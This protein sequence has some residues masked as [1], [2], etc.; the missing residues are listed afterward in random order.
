MVAGGRS[1]DITHGYVGD[2]R[3]PV[4]L[5][6]SETAHRVRRQQPGEVLDGVHF[7]NRTRRGCRSR[8]HVLRASVDLVRIA[9]VALLVV[10]CA[11][12]IDGPVERQQ[13]ADRIDSARL[14]SQLGQL[15]GAVRA[16]VTLHRPTIDR[17]TQTATPGSAAILV[18]IDDRADRRAITRSTIALARG[19]A[20]EISEPAIVVE[21]GATRPTLASVGPFTVEARSKRLVVATLAIACALIAV[22]AGWIA[23]R[24]RIARGES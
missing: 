2:R 21:I 5:Q 6:C 10:A 23:W 8:T 13:Q 12:T 4:R 1:V 18:V 9:L 20:P 15:P 7:N 3:E 22:L 14:A 11:P 19:T 24:E 17:L 16:E